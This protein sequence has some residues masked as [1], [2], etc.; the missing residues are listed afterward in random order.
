MRWAEPVA[1]QW[2]RRLLLPAVPLAYDTW[3]PT[4]TSSSSWLNRDSNIQP[5]PEEWNCRS[6]SLLLWLLNEELLEIRHNPPS[7]LLPSAHL[8][9]ETSLLLTETGNDTSMNNSTNIIP[10]CQL[11]VHPLYMHGSINQWR[12]RIGILAEHKARNIFGQWYWPSTWFWVHAIKS[13]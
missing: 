7:D 10:G 6:Q 2:P 4:R 11:Q 5:Q 1:K 13:K 8:G 12:T 9:F 3:L